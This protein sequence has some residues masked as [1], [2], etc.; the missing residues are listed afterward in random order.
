M[1]WKRQKF[2]NNNAG[3][4]L[5]KSECMVKKFLLFAWENSVGK[6]FSHANFADF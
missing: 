4:H 5:Y 6:V 1:L 2:T 3:L